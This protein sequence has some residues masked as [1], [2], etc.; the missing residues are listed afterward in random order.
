MNNAKEYL[1]QIRQLNIKIKCIEADIEALREEQITLSSIRLDGMPHG[2]KIS[3]PTAEKAVK[4]VD[5]LATMESKL[6]DAKS[7]YWSK[8][9]EV[10]G[11]IS[12]VDDADLNEL[13]YLRYVQLETFEGIAYKMS[14]SY[15]HTLRL[16]GRALEEV[17]RL[18]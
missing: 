8:R 16:H 1:N 3:D 18:I 15:R 14:Y 12:K 5:T 2:T 4:L 7:E 13:L 10:I 17:G 9:M 6:M 11:V